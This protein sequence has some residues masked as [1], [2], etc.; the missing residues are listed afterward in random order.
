MLKKKLLADQYIRAIKAR[1]DTIALADAYLFLSEAFSHSQTAVHYA[2]SIIQL[3]QQIKDNPIYPSEGY[4]QKGIQHYYIANFD[5]AL[6]YYLI[7]D[8]YYKAQKNKFKQLVVKH[9]VGILK[10][11]TNEF[12]EAFWIFKENIKFFENEE[13]KKRYEIQYLKSLYALANGFVLLKELDSAEHYSRI[14]LK[15]SS[16]L[17]N[18]NLYPHFL[19]A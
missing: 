4:L 3:T 13:N 10:N 9:Y 16:E 12:D 8:T 1:Q 5:Q 6:R 11:N 14:G 2:D 7:A 17:G 18:T 19:L 15:N